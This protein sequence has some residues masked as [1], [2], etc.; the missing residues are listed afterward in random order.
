MREDEWLDPEVPKG[1]PQGQVDAS[2]NPSESGRFGS[3]GVPIEPTIDRKPRIPV[4][5]STSTSSSGVND[6]TS[7]RPA[8]IAMAAIVA[9]LLLG[10][11]A[12]TMLGS[13]SDLGGSASEPSLSTGP[14]GAAGPG[15]SLAMADTGSPLT[16]TR[17]GLTNP[18]STADPTAPETLP[19]VLPPPT[20]ATV[21]EFPGRIVVETDDISFAG[22]ST[23]ERLRLVNEGGGEADW[24]V[25]VG[26]GSGLWLSATDG[27]LR[28]G[29][30]VEVEVGLDRASGPDATDWAVNLLVIGGGNT[31]PGH[32]RVRVFPPA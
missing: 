7:N 5:V 25:S 1:N 15:G 16:T 31:S 10:L 21:P 32:I 6:G 9:L 24:Q 29:E 12:L 4:P 20:N 23:S 11:G 22:G 13:G 14:A 2:K 27:R 28:P 19:T 17:S 3:G 18:S 8:A 26:A 30:T